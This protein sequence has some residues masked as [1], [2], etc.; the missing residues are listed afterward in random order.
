MGYLYLFTE[1]WQHRAGAKSDVCD[2]LIFS[3]KQ[4][5]CLNSTRMILAGMV[6]ECG[7]R[8]PSRSQTSCY[9]AQRTNGQSNLSLGCIA[10]KQSLYI[11]TGRHTSP[12]KVPRSVG[13]LDPSF[14][15][16]PLTQST[17]YP[18]IHNKTLLWA[19]A[20]WPGVHEVQGVARIPLV[21]TRLDVRHSLL[22]T[23][24]RAVFDGGLGGG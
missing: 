6:S 7:I 15:Y 17:S 2:C 9:T 4:S 18:I 5:V 22:R 14:L 11:T 8:G 20:C 3:S 16:L 21:T 23:D 24:T 19:G 1:Q 12:S 10:A 13:D